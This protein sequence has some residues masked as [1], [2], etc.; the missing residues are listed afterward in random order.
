MIGAVTV[1]AV[2]T[3]RLGLEGLRELSERMP[4]WIVNSEENRLA[5]EQIWRNGAR[6]RVTIFDQDPE[7]H[8][9]EQQLTIVP[10]IKEHLG[11]YGPDDADVVIE[12]IGLALT[13]AV[14]NYLRS[15]GFEQF[16]ETEGGFKAIRTTT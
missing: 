13:E 15:L 16:S 5:V 1:A 11:E 7:G 10:V 2:L 12:V 9:P 3:R 6:G 14:Q 8:S 4:V